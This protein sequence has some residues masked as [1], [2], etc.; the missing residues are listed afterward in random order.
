[1]KIKFTKMHGAGNDFLILDDRA[2]AFPDQDAALVARLAA[3]RFG[4]GCEG[5]L[6]LRQADA[7]TDFD[8]KMV[9]LNPDGSRAA[10]C[11]NAS[12]CVALFAFELGIGGRCQR[13]LADAG[14]ITAEIL[15]AG[16]G[17]GIVRIH[18]TKPCGRAAIVNVDLPGG[19]TAECFKVDTGV[20]HA[21]VFVDDVTSVDVM[22][23]GRAIRNAA[24]FAPAGTNADFVQELEPGIAWMRTC[25]RGVEAE[26]GACGT[27]AL[28]AG[29]AL[30][31]RRGAKLPVAIRVGSGDVLIVDGEIGESGL[32]CGMTL[33]GPARKVFEGVVDTEWLEGA[34]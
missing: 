26:S 22:G 17:R 9:F 11:G 31:E 28:A 13:I 14:A 19:R 20:P 8:Y 25:E 21:V 4:V 33:T 6:A 23:D 2:G 3:R 27:G 32:C 29:I 10:M 16:R 30:A 24:A 1:M 5:V 7:F 18:A 12:R 34:N 15:E